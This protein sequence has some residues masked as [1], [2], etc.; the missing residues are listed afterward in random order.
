M[1]AIEVRDLITIV[2]IFVGVGG[3]VIG[4]LGHRLKKSDQ[5]RTDREDRIRE[6]KEEIEQ[7]KD[8]LRDAERRA[9][10][11]ERLYWELR[12]ET[13]AKGPKGGPGGD[14]D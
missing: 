2:G 9:E 12:E 7:H 3:F 14:D 11:Y 5:A 1:G 6:L 4:M 10:R 8:D 13:R